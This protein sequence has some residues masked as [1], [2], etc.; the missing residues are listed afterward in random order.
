MK[1][2]GGTNGGTGQFFIGSIMMCVGFYMLFQA[3]T[4]SSTFGMRTGLYSFHLLG[5]MRTLNTGM[6]LIPFIFGIGMIFYNAKN[7]IG[8][9]LTIGSLSAVIFGVIASLNIH[10]KTMSFFEI[11]TILVLCFGGIGLF[12]S[13]L[14]EK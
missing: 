6:I 3:I 5:T 7:I 8:W 4:V 9:L 10:M 1:G 13:S 12:L 11:S 2:A 14:K